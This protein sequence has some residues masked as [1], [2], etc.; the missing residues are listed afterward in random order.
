MIKEQME[1]IYKTMPAEKIPWNIETPPEILKQIV[2][3]KKINPCKSIELGCGT[4]NYVIY[5][6][7]L[8][9]QATGVDI[10]ETAIELARNSAS[11]KGVECKFMSTDVL[12]AMSEIQDTFDFVYD[13]ELLHHIFPEDREKYIKNVYRLLNPGGNYLS[14]CFSE[15]SPQFGGVG[16]YRKS[17]IDTILYF[18]SE[19]EIKS[20][21]EAHFEIEVLK[22]V[23][24]AGK[25]AP[26]KAVYALSKKR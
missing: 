21:I 25:Y 26:H 8:G 13:W 14:V 2:S 7:G 22:T 24:I 23:E 5:L 1:N 15:Q 11:S 9:F 18:S 4:G 10:S 20:L 16:K 19:S 17:P 3:T 12:G 6:A